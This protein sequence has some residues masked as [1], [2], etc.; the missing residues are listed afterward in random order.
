MHA[1]AAQPAVEQS[2]VDEGGK[3]CRQRETGVLERHHQRQIE[4]EVYDKGD[5]ADPHRRAHVLARE[6]AGR[7]H[8]D[9]HEADQTDCVGNQAEARHMHVARRE[10][11]VLEQCRE[12]RIGEQDEP[13]RGRHCHQHHPA[14]GPVEGVG[15]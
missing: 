10:L 6:I 13:Q 14:H 4:N 3:R 1:I 9:E 7:E 5:D 2:R 8:F 12:N 15:E 11:A